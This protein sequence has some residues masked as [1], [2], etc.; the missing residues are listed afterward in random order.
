MKTSGEKK[1]DDI[2]RQGLEQPGPNANFFEED[3][4]AMEAL[5]DQKKK[6]GI[7]YILPIIS[8]IAAMLLLCLGLFFITGHKTQ[9]IVK[10]GSGVI[11]SLPFD[12]KQNSNTISESPWAKLATNTKPTKD[13]VSGETESD[14][15]H[16]NAALATTLASTTSTK[17]SAGR[18][19]KKHTGTVTGFTA[20]NTAAQ[21]ANTSKEINSVFLTNNNTELDL[22][23]ITDDALK[24]QLLPSATKAQIASVANTHKVT[25]QSGPKKIQY[26]ITV[27]AS[28]NVN[29]VSTFQN[30]MVGANVGILFSVGLSKKFT[31]STGAMYA[32][33]P[34]LTSFADYHTN[35][36]F[37]TDPQNVTADC[38]VLDIPINI[39]YQ[40]YSSGSNKFTIGTGVSSYLMLRENY[41]Y[42]YEYA[43]TAGPT[44]YNIVNK[45]QHFLGVLNLDATYQRKLNSKFS[46]GIQPYLKVPLTNIGYSQVKLQS[47][48]LAVGVIWNLNTARK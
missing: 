16:I 2:F 11:K 3:W 47:A 43:G 48:G 36:K 13:T 31:I 37:K 17:N 40:L 33:A 30:S 38:R 32:K 24:N 5:L 8:G 14:A 29:G 20:Q 19:T 46:L 34:Y 35:Y 25:K 7:I 10:R 9:A 26:A 1:L 27:L 12:T 41:H 44:D 21:A 6:R 45:N 15:K 28:P 22:S 23:D 42:N 39:D 4:E 18:N